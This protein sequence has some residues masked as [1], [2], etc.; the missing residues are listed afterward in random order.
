MPQLTLDRHSMDAS[1]DTWS[2][3]HG[4]L[5]WHLI[6]TPWIPQLILDR[7]S[8]DTSVDTWSTLHGHVT[9]QSVGRVDFLSMQLC[10]STLGQL[11][12]DCWSRVNLMYLPRYWSNIDCDV[13][14]GY[15]SMA[16]AF[17]IHDPKILYSPS[18]EVSPVTL[19][20][21]YF[22]RVLTQR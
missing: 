7:H 11:S 1:V 20:F 12:T 4:H 19:S 9:Q 5:S 3:L 6:D 21:F 22:V 16:E 17:S 14:W 2:A 15:Q 13:N 10:C 18:S 8:R